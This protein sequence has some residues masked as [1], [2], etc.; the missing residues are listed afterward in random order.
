MCCAAGTAGAVAARCSE[1]LHLLQ[2]LQASSGVQ[3][4]SG[5]GHR[6]S[7][8]RLLV[9]VM[10]AHRQLF[11]T[12]G[13]LLCVLALHF[14]TQ[15]P[16]A[17]AG[18]KVVNMSIVTTHASVAATS[19]SMSTTNQ[20]SMATNQTSVATNQTSVT[21]YDQALV[22]TNQTSVATSNQASV[23]TNQ[24]SV[25]ATSASVATS[26][27]ALVATNQTSVATASASMA[28][29]NHTSVTTTTTWVSISQASVAAN[30]SMNHTEQTP[31]SCQS[32]QCSGERCYQD[33]AHSNMT[34]TCYN[35]TFCE[36]WSLERLL[37]AVSTTPDFPLPLSHSVHYFC[38][39]VMASLRTSSGFF[40]FPL[41]LLLQLY[42]F[43]S[44]NYTARCSSVCSAEL[45]RTNGSVTLQQCTMECC[46]TS[47]CLQLN[48][49]SYGDLPPTTV[50]PTTT[51][52][53]TTT[54]RPPPRNVGTRC[55][56]CAKAASKG[57]QILNELC[58]M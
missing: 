33:E 43:S 2:Q 13:L 12:P 45:C 34:T 41:A 42:R 4:L 3:G 52:T 56:L 44:M 23:A 58:K 9:G 49:S 46:N 26:N 51:I 28:A 31:L 15:G 48:A 19:A 29:S 11:P 5:H 17:I 25:S 6:G 40:F 18:R 8:L 47:L 27:Q 14:C 24:A 53:T 32:F 16:L 7:Q 30:A 37:E 57:E 54:P 50:L 10:A 39:S 38:S 22:A 55:D 1:A 21:T 20:A 35:E 36:V